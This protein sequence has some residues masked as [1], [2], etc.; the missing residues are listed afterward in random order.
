MNLIRTTLTA[1]LAGT[2]ITGC[3]TQ[4]A[5]TAPEDP[6]PRSTSASEPTEQVT[7]TPPDPT[8]LPQPIIDATSDW[9]PLTTLHITPYATQQGQLDA[10]HMRLVSTWM[11]NYA[12]HMY[13]DERTI[14]APDVATVKKRYKKWGSRVM[15]DM[16]DHFTPGEDGMYYGYLANSMTRLP[17]GSTLLDTS[18]ATYSWNAITADYDGLAKP[19]AK[20]TLM[21]R[22]LYHYKDPDG[23]VRALPTTRWLS[24]AT[25]PTNTFTT[26]SEHG[27]WNIN[28]TATEDYEVCTLLTDGY[29]TT[30]STP[31]ELAPDAHPFFTTPATTYLSPDD[32]GDQH[33]FM[34]TKQWKKTR[35][36]CS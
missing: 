19:G 25:T 9:T 31:D 22:I 10:R 34:T 3:T 35:A 27:L 30:T 23:Q 5:D 2:L 8:A 11:I 29:L 17:K 13:L 16:G 36:S 14:L 4:P 12:N 15:N 7:N 1:L 6:A 33:P 28:I 32:F 21:L 18:V 24:V 26:Y 20:L